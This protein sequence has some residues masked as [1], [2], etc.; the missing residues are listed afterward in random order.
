MMN[1][2]APMSIATRSK[3]YTKSREA[4]GKEI[5]DG[6]PPPPASGPL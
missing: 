5:T 2:P 6:P 1:D 3:N 4:V